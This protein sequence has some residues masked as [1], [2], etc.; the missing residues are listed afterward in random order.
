MT[1]PAPDSGKPAKTIEEMLLEATE[2]RDSL[3]RLLREVTELI[4][5]TRERLKNPADASDC[6]SKVD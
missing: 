6:R 1:Y 2:L 4:A 5:K 3:E